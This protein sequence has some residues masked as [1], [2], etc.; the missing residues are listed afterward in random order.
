MR[1]GR[2]VVEKPGDGW[3]VCRSSREGAE[4]GGCTPQFERTTV[5]FERPKL[6]VVDIGSQ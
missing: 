3:R 2:G 5:Y 1:D 4:A 6:W